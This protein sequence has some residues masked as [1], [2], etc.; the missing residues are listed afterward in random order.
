MFTKKYIYVFILLSF[1]ACK[2]DALKTRSKQE[3]KL[4][5]DSAYSPAIIENKLYKGINDRNLEERL[6]AYGLENNETIVLLKT[7]KGD[8][9]IRLYKDTP[10]HR[11][12]FIL[13]AKNGCFDNTVF[14]RVSK[15]FM[16]Q[17]GGT[18]DE[19]MVARRNEIGRYTLPNEIRPHHFH[20]Q[21][22]IGAGRSY[23]N[24]P[25]KRSSPFAFYIVEGETYNEATLKKYEEVNQYTFPKKHWEYYL[26]NPGAAHIDG[27]HTVFGEVIE[28]IG[29]IPLLTHVATD[30]RDWPVDDIFIREVRVIE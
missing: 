12:S 11:A 2:E 14:T 17:A 5:P 7:D 16:A 9:R 23:S 21:G 3:N 27:Q 4:S 18:Y 28:G 25:E 19:K 1:V 8:I 29:I 20:K 13:M 22:A 6:T 26:N 10:L 15:E 24:N 30:S